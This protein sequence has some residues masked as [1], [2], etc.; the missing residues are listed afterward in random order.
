LVLGAQ[1][2]PGRELPLVQAGSIS[3]DL[4][5]MGPA[6]PLGD[7]PVNFAARPKPVQ[8]A[9]WRR[10]KQEYASWVERLQN[11]NSVF[12]NQDSDLHQQ[13]AFSDTTDRIHAFCVQIYD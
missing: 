11:L 9:R 6:A 7:V 3:M 13:V 10:K 1:S 2:V 8:A 5:A 12:E 4:V